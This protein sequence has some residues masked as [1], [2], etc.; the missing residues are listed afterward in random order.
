MSPLV[1]RLPPFIDSGSD[2]AYSVAFS[3]D[4]KIVAAG[5]SNGRAYLWNVAT[6]KPVSTLSDSVSKGVNSVAFSPDG[7]V[8][9]AGDCNGRAYLWN[10]ATGK[11]VTYSLRL[12]QQGGELGRV[13]PGRQVRGR[14]R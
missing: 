9:A 11:P 14:R 6:G 12:C 13:Q 8:V 2:G 3:P 1:A 4:G 7:K 10:V 5:D